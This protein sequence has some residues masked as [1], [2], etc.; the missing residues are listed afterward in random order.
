MP[1]PD[2]EITYREPDPSVDPTRMFIDYCPWPVHVLYHPI[3][4]SP[5]LVLMKPSDFKIYE[6]DPVT[7]CT[8]IPPSYEQIHLKKYELSIPSENRYSFDYEGIIK[9]WWYGWGELTRTVVIGTFDE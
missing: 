2:Q 4:R 7:P 3:K 6:Y 8:Y 9:S 5:I 1:E